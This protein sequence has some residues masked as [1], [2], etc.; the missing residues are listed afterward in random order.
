M[1]KVRKS[2]KKNITESFSSFMLADNEIDILINIMNKLKNKLEEFI[3][4]MNFRNKIK[5]PDDLYS[6]TLRKTSSSIRLA[7]TI[8]I[9]DL[10]GE[11]EKNISLVTI[12]TKTRLDV[13][14]LTDKVL[15]LEAFKCNFYAY[16][17]IVLSLDSMRCLDHLDLSEYLNAQ[18]WDSNY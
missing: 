13:D 5:S 2:K 1:S 7:G 4:E 6:L 8:L 17:N 14:S 11:R 15:E 18:S 12:N 9:S 3:D 16:R 10:E